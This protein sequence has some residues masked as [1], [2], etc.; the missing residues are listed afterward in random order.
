LQAICLHFSK[1]EVGLD[2][3]LRWWAYPIFT[4]ADK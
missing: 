4:V 3:D 1:T 2:A